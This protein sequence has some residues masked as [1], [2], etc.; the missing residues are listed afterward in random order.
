MLAI[1]AGRDERINAYIPAIEAAMKENG[2]TFNKIVYPDVDHA[3]HNDTGP[4]YNA[5]QAE[6]AWVATINWFHHYVR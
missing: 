3:F 5:T 2:K 1:Y 4:R 6:A